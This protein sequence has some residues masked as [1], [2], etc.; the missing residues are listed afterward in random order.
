MCEF[1]DHEVHTHQSHF[2][3]DCGGNEEF[4]FLWFW[5]RAHIQ[6]QGK[7]R[8]RAS[9]DLQWDGHQEYGHEDWIHFCIPS[10]SEDRRTV[11]R[12]FSYGS[13]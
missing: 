6:A 12:E 5:I 2:R 9:A 3:N 1:D 8:G 4:G 13:A 10:C 7:Q 11:L